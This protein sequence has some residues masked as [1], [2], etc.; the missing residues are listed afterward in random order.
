MFSLS[1]HHALVTGAATG[2][3]EAIARRLTAAGAKVAI[4]DIDQF[5]SGQDSMVPFLATIGAPN[6]L[7]V[8]PNTKLVVWSGKTFAPAGNVTVSSGGVGVGVAVAVG[9]GVSL[10]TPVGVRVG[11]TTRFSTGGLLNSSTGLG[12]GVGS[13]CG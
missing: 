12:L 2:I 5:D 4:A 8:E 9:I 7:V 1:G 3:G 11:S 10:A 13:T 6:T